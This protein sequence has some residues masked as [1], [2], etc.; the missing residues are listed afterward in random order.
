MLRARGRQ[1]P[2]PHAHIQTPTLTSSLTRVTALESGLL[3]V[4][5]ELWGDRDGAACSHLF[6]Q[7]TALN[8]P[9]AEHLPYG[10]PVSCRGETKV[11][12]W[13]SPPASPPPFHVATTCHP[14]A[15]A[16]GYMDSAQTADLGGGC[17][18]PNS[19]S[20][21]GTQGGCVTS[22]TPHPAP[23]RCPLCH[24]RV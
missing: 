12:Q 1:D 18:R 16:S 21:L 7:R 22:H 2:P 19:S 11:G 13:G 14:G 8:W 4:L 24:W 10:A 17:L 5:S 9:H 6:S 23:G 15:G 3:L 20:S